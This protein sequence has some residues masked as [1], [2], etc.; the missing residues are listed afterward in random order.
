[1]KWA[2][3]TNEAR[4]ELWLCVLGSE[5]DADEK[6]GTDGT[7]NAQAQF[8][9]INDPSARARPCSIRELIWSP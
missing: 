6:S 9:E 8:G 7:I 4:A 1:M 5:L 2:G 3:R